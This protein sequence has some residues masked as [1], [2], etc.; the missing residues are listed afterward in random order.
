ME[1]RLQGCPETAK[2]FRTGQGKVERRF[3]PSYY[4]GSMTVT[5]RS[6]LK[7]AILSPLAPVAGHAVNPPNAKRG[8]LKTSLNAFSFN[9]QLLDGSM[10]L[11]D[12]FAFCAEKGFSAVDITAYYFPGYPNVPPDRF[13]YDTKMSAFRAGLDISGTGVRNDFT[14]PD[15]N[16]RRQSVLLV[17]A[18]IEAAEKI[19]APVIRIFSGTQSPPGYTRQ[20]IFDWMLADIRECVNYGKSH[21]VVVGIQNHNDFI[22]TADQAIEILDRIDSPW[23]GL[24]LDTGSYRTG[25]AYDEIHKTAA[26]AVNWQVKEKLFVAGEEVEA[27][28]SRIVSIIQESGYKGYLPIETLG[29]GDPKQKISAL[30]DKLNTALGC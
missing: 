22:A 17:K 5:R 21:G 9:K 27:D 16:K 6:L 3:A 11:T 29:E 14:E 13:L 23:F 19:G 1:K 25:D 20:Q 10:S 15:A 30:L 18:W 4:F 2:S 12:M 7:A 24:I 8:T 26:Y 28:I